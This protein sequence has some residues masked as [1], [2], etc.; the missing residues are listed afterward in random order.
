MVKLPTV[1]HNRQWSPTSDYIKNLAFKWYISKHAAVPEDPEA[2]FAWFFQQQ[3]GWGLSMYEQDWMCLECVALPA[4]V[5][6]RAALAPAPT[7][8]ER[9]P[10]SLLSTALSC[11]HCSRS[12]PL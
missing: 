8:F 6:A 9:P 10:L 1:M 5:I 7:L 3:E 11:A 12:Y 2:F 4:L